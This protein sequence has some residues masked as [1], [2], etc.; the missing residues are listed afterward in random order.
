MRKN[1]CHIKAILSRAEQDVRDGL[2][3]KAITTLNALPE[4]GKAE[5]QGW[6]ARAQERVDVMTALDE[7][8]G[9]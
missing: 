6:I 4:E 1:I 3:A 9:Q 5:M 2:F 7:F 8:L